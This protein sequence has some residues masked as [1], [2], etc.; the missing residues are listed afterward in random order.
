[1]TF[2]CFNLYYQIHTNVGTSNIKRI[3]ITMIM[4][5]VSWKNVILTHHANVYGGLSDLLAKL[6]DYIIFLISL[7]ICTTHSVL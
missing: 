1:M 3:A 5:I 6:L 4:Y 2:K 7:V